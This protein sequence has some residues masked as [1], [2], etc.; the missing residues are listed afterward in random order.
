MATSAISTSRPWRSTTSSEG[1]HHEIAS[2]PLACRSA[3]PRTRCDAHRQSD[4]AAPALVARGQLLHPR[5]GKS[6]D[7]RQPAAARAGPGR[8]AAGNRAGGEQRAVH[9]DARQRPS[10]PVRRHR[11]HRVCGC[12]RRRSGGCQRH[13]DPDLPRALRHPGRAARLQQ[14]RRQGLHHGG[15]SDLRRRGSEQR[16]LGVRQHRLGHAG[17][18]DRHREQR[19]VR[20]GRGL[21]GAR[22]SDHLQRVLSRSVSTQGDKPMSLFRKSRLATFAVACALGVGCGLALAPSEGLADDIDIYSGLSAGN[23]DMPNIIFLVD[24]SPNWSRAAQHWPDNGGTPGSGGGYIR[25][26]ARDMT[27][28]AN[29]TALQNILAG[30]AAN[31]NSPNEKLTGMSSKDEDGGFYEVYKYL[32]GLAPFTGPYG[33]SY[34]AQNG[35]VD[36]A[37]NAS[38]YTAASQGLTSGYAIVGGNYVS[39]ISSTKP[40]ARTYIV[41]LANHANNIGSTGQAAYQAAIANVAPA[42][43][44]TP[45][46]ATWTDEWTKSLSSSG[47]V[48]PAGNHNASVVTYVLDAYS[49]QQNVGYSNSLMSAAKQGGGKYFQVGKVADIQNALATIFAEIQAVNSTF[50][51]VTL[52]LNSI[53]KTEVD[54]EVFIP[55]FRPD[56]NDQPRWMGNLKRY[57]MA[58]SAQLVGS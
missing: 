3:R 1:I 33:S 28:A 51:S 37:G 32:S 9:P 12:Q 14:S 46:Q 36:I 54:N 16:K 8:G 34:A 2:H 56:A 5:Q 4:H 50:A 44:A 19:P 35:Y 41:Y 53:N 43:V 10:E 17:D 38:A 11:E 21:R 58:S 52:P 57:A 22:R 55:V 13:R 6:A 18:G 29:K 39:P 27:V 24:N 7:R 20:R 42:L 45:L 30:I 26:A 40:C 47:A 23:S 48:V 31:I 25:F 15:Q 49:S